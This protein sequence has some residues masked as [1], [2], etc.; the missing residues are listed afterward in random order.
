MS[1]IYRLLASMLFL[2]FITAT[3][4]AN[5][6]LIIKYKPSNKQQQLHSAGVMSQKQLNSQMML[7]LTT[8]RMSQISQVAGVNLKEVSQ[9]GNGAHV[10]EIQQDNLTPEQIQN[11]IQK[12]KN[13]DS[14]IQYVEVSHILKPMTMPVYNQSKQWDMVESINGDNFQNLQNNWNGLYPNES[15]GNGVIVAVIDTGY[16]PHSNFLNHLVPYSA[17]TCSTLSGGATAP[18]CYG[19]TFM[20]SCSNSHAPNCNS[21]T[22]YQPDALDWGDWT[23]TENSSWHGSHVTGTIVANGYTTGNTVLGGAY[24]AR[25]LPI[26]SLGSGG[27]NDY[28]IAN[29]ILWA[30]NQYSGI[31]NSTKAQI[32]SMSLGGVGACGNTM[33]DAIN[34]AVTNGAIVIA[35]AGNADCSTGTCYVYNVSQISPANCNN[36][37][38]V[39]AKGNNATSTNGLA[40]YSSYGNTS[41]TAS[42]GNA[43]PTST[44]SPYE[45]WSDVWN[46]ATV[47]KTPAQG[48]DSTYIAYEGTSQATPHVSAAI[49]DLITYFNNIGVT[50]NLTTIIDILQQSASQLTSKANVN[51]LRPGQGGTVSG[52]TLNAN[53]ALLY[54]ESL[55]SNISLVASPTSWST[56]NTTPQTL[57]FTNE[58]SYSVLVE[59]YLIVMPSDSSFTFGVS[60][61]TCSG[62]TL[63]Q[64]ESCAITLTLSSYGVGSATLQLLNASN[65]ISFVPITINSSAP[66]PSGGSSGGGGC[67]TIANGD[68]Y[69]IILILSSL[70]IIYYFKRRCFKK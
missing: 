47:Y 69:S 14:T 11:I 33:Q 62:K 40:W 70:S 25:V 6:R 54:A 59:S 29:A 28:D 49:A 27:G 43:K 16:T 17:G 42:G 19:Y 30:V 13:G 34:T 32:I 41:I 8:T 53:N 68:D 38:S 50:Y 22:P 35:A 52:L 10:M 5:E 21:N 56:T 24:G 51:D 18:Q 67:S 58:S 63:H 44:T 7:P 61:N 3:A 9:V 45:T 31:S 60:N 15:P 66:T 12:I 64:N 37:I 46:E 2:V 65:Q 55:Y 36:V 39:S 26:R 4:M 20:S 57:T 23:S 1:N 48:G